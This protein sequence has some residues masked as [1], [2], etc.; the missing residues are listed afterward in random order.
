MQAAEH[1]TGVVF[2]KTGLHS[3][4]LLVHLSFAVQVE[5]KRADRHIGRPRDQKR[6]R[7]EENEKL[8]QAF[9]FADLSAFKWR[10]RLVIRAADLAAYFLIKLIGSTVRFEVEGWK[11]LEEVMKDGKVPI[12]SF[13]HN[14]MLIGTYFFRNRRIIVMTSK[15]FDAAISTR[16]IQR[17]GYG[18][19]RGSST[20]GGS[21]AI[22]EMIK[23]MQA[24]CPAG[25]TIDGPRGPKFVAKSGAVLLAKKS[26]NPLMPLAITTLRFWE[27]RSW[28]KLQLPKPFTRAR[29]VIAPPIWV[30]HD[31][32]D[33]LIDAKR[34][35]LQAALDDLNLD[36]ERWR[37]GEL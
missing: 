30:P 25:L 34:E 1:Y 3:L 16:L 4:V 8:A 17:F 22:I 36:G 5:K 10:E 24:G 29:V 14:Q 18:A 11:N 21:R 15:S 33:Y 35:E 2:R 19:A 37:A 20:R 26:G 12:Y 6:K 27:A 13:W 9:R 28:D 23:L 31:A 32:D 7:P